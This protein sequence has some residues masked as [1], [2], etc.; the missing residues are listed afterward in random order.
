MLSCPACGRSLQPQSRYCPQ[1]GSEIRLGSGS[2]LKDS[3]YCITQ[4]LSKGGMGAVYLATDRRAFDRLCVVKQMI[5][6]YDP[7]DPAERERAAQ[8]FEE[9]GRTLASLSHPG[10]PQIYAFFQEGGRFY[11]VMEYIRGDNLESFV[12]HE[13]EAGN[14]VHNKTLPREEIVRYISQVCDI[15]EYLHSQTRPVVH[16][17]IKPANL[18]L[19]RQRGIVRLVDFG[20]ARIHAPQNESSSQVGTNNPAPA[21]MTKASIYGTDGYAPP[22]QYKGKP[23]P[24]SDVFA[25]AA[26]AYHL[27]TDDDPRQH[28]FKFPHLSDLPKELSIALERALRTNPEQRSTA[29]DLRQALEALSSP[30]RTLETFTF[31]GG[32]QIRSVAA[33]P[34]LCDEHWDA[35]R[36]FLYRGDFQRWLRDINR[37]DLV[38]AADEII[39][40]E[41]NQDAGLETFLHIIDAG[42]PHPKLICDPTGVDLGRIAR[43]SAIIRRVTL[44]NARRGYTQAQVEAS[45]PWIELYPAS[46]H[47][48]AGIPSDIRIHVRAEALPLRSKQQ[49]VVTVRT[50]NHPPVE[51]PVTA[52]VSLL[53]EFGRLIRR[54]LSAAVPQSW[55]TVKAGWQLVGRVGRGVG[56]PFVAHQWLVWFAWIILGAAIGAGLYFMPAG[57]SVHLAAGYALQAPT[58]W[59]DYVLPVLVGPPLI[60]SLIWLAFI[61]VVVFGG[62]LAGALWGAWKSFFA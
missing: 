23:V 22:E 31:P 30:K 39:H 24:Q 43:E 62:A 45:A 20:T 41:E 34:A 56:G 26:T 8:R 37:H 3:D 58:A 18:I 52:Q 40:R 49:A 32:T 44:L 50:A 19:D 2:A 10:A 4:A 35:A 25:L 47:L 53:H 15:L 5:D 55:Q 14:V 11:I 51:I 60:V 12:T 54:A 13:D 16:Q 48:W 28:P 33:L 27:L 1:C 29:R 6:Y 57:V 36:S 7:A 59:S 61:V 42:L 46:L 9:E 38:L 21:D 17:D